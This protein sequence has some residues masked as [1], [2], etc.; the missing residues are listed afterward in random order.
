MVISTGGLATI[1]NGPFPYPS[2]WQITLASVLYVFE[3]VLFVVFASLLPLRWIRYPHV[4]VGRALRE[5]SELG[6]YAIPPIALLTIS[7]LTASQVSSTTWGGH[8][9]TVVAYMLW[10]V[11]VVWVFATLLVVLCTL[12][13]TGNQVDRIMTPVLFMAPVGLATAGTEAGFISIFA[14]DMSARMAVPMLVVGYFAVGVALFM[15]IVL[16]TV[17]FHRLLSAGWGSPL[18]R[19]ANFILVGATGRRVKVFAYGFRLVPVGSCP[20]RSSCSESRHPRTCVLPS[21]SH[22]LSIHQRMAPFG[23]KRRRRGLTA[24]DSSLHSSLDSTICGAA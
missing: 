18:E 8:S 10:W 19:P 7:G 3:I 11:G 9:F 15:A 23:D 2:G 4:A 6:S 13:Y 17:Y 24:R 21:I 1:L 20:L 14:T 12:F 22:N 16:Y 5:P